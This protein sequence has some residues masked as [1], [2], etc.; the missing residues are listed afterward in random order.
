[1][2]S[3][4]SCDAPAAVSSASRPR[5]RT[6]STPGWSSQVAGSSSATTAARPDAVAVSYAGSAWTSSSLSAVR[7][8]DACSSGS[9]SR[10]TASGTFSSTSAPTVSSPSTCVDTV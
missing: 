6:P 7:S 1:M 8:V 4:S 9:A 3:A 2:R 10:S 5:T